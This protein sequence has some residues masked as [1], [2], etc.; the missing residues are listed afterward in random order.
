MEF[1]KTIISYCEAMVDNWYSIYD[2]ETEQKFPATVV[3]VKYENLFHNDE[4]EFNAFFKFLRMDT[5]ALS[6]RSLVYPD[7]FDSTITRNLYNAY[8]LVQTRCTSFI[9][10]YHYQLLPLEEYLLSI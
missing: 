5:N 10:T 1:T 7:K 2:I 4:E 9:E 6:F 3:I 8:N